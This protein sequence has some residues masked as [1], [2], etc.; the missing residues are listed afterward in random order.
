M[1]TRPTE[2]ETGSATNE[3]QRTLKVHRT[4]DGAGLEGAPHWGRRGGREGLHHGGEWMSD[5][6]MIRAVADNS[7]YDDVERPEPL[8]EPWPTIW[9]RTGE[10]LHM[11]G[12]WA[13]A[14]Q[15]WAPAQHRTPLGAGSGTGCLLPLRVASLRA[16][17]GKG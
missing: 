2:G 3:V 7:C 15:G 12:S 5:R 13:S 8:P 14:E 11:T 16:F 9:Y 17:A 4:A 1:E 6:E 10:A